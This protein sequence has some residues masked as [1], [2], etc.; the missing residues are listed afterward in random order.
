MNV[1]GQNAALLFPNVEEFDRK[2]AVLRVSPT[3]TTDEPR[4]TVYMP[5]FGRITARASSTSRLY[6]VDVNNRGQRRRFFTSA[7]TTTKNSI[8]DGKGHVVRTGLIKKNT[9]WA[10]HLFLKRQRKTGER[11]GK[12]RCRGLESA[13]VRRVWAADGKRIGARVKVHKEPEGPGSL[14]CCLQTDWSRPLYFDQ[15]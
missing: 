12:L 1:K 8:M 2:T 5:L 4:S 9:R 3:S 6:N 15:K 10:D 13:G 7:A 11:L 14:R